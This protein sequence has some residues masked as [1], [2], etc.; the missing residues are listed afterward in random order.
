MSQRNCARCSRRKAVERLQRPETN[1]NDCADESQIR[2]L[3]QRSGIKVLQSPSEALLLALLM[4]ALVTTA[5]AFQLPAASLRAPASRAACV[6]SDTQ[7]YLEKSVAPNTM[8]GAVVPTGA[9]PAEAPD[10]RETRDEAPDTP[11]P[12]WA[13]KVSADL[14]TYNDIL[15]AQSATGPKRVPVAESAPAPQPF[16]V[17]PAPAPASSSLLNSRTA[18]IVG[19]LA[20]A[21]GAVFG[22]LAITS[23]TA[24]AAITLDE[25]ITAQRN[26]GDALVGISNTY[27]SGGDFIVEASKAADQLYGYGRTDV[28]FKPTKAADTPFRPTAQGALSY[29]IGGDKVLTGGYAEDKGFALGPGGVGWKKVVFDNNKVDLNGNTAQAMG[30][31]YFYPADGGS[32]AKVEYT[33]GYKRNDDGKIRIYLHHSSL[34]YVPH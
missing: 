33:F 15:K 13:S 22:T 5:L 17:E 10:M 21:S 14:R 29:F 16:E 28:L 19:P 12:A 27:L 3:T 30:E 20:L 24:P 34:P 2:H 26:W 32:P 11:L 23:A 25:I 18:R 1:A 4:L 9:A 7:D 6:M 8:E 31:Y